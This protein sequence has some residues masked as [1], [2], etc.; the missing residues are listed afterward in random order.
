[1]QELTGDFQTKTDKSWRADPP[2]PRL[3]RSPRLQ[4][5][6]HMKGESS[7][8]TVRVSGFKL[9]RATQ[10]VKV[11]DARKYERNLKQR[12]T[13]KYQMFL[14]IWERAINTLQMKTTSRVLKV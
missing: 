6:L 12:L 5:A 13:T 8:W 10:L 14:A 7:L 1:M 2:I 3:N 4:R 9:A 11:L